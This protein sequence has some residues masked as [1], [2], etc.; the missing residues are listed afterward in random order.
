MYVPTGKTSFDIYECFLKI[1]K[2]FNHMKQVTGYKLREYEAL[3]KGAV[4]E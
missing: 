4:M 1:R 2:Y 3:D